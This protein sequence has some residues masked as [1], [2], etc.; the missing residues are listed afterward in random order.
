[1][2]GLG[3]ALLLKP[4]IVVAMFAAWYF[5][6][7]VPLRLLYRRLPKNRVV[8]FLFRERGSQGAARAA[9]ADHRALQ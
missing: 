7:L 4:L 1:M 6:V 3:W 2:T 9:D 5:L 8:E